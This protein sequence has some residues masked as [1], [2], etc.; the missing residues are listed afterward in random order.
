M[1][2][3]GLQILSKNYVDEGNGESTLES[4]S[5]YLKWMFHDDQREGKVEVTG[6]LKF[7]G[8]RDL[9]YYRTIQEVKRKSRKGLCQR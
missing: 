4:G 5:E 1:N 3:F 2:E 8:S 7:G 6:C 9:I